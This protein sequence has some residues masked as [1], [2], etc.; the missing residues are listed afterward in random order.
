MSGIVGRIGAKS[1][2]VTVPD[3]QILS[4]NRARELGD[5]RYDPWKHN[6]KD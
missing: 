2:I 6:P 1:G 5:K 3:N 4:F